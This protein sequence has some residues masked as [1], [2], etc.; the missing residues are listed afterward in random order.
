MERVATYTVNAQ[1]TSTQLND[2]QDVTV[3]LISGANNNALSAAGC[4]GCEWQS[5]TANI[6]SATQIK[7]DAT[8]DWRDRVLT[9]LYYAPTGANEQPGGIADYQYD[10]NIPSLRKG[11]TGRGGLDA[12]SADPSNGNPPVPAA[13][14]SW[15]LEVDANIYLYASTVDGSLWLYNDSGGV[16]K[17]PIL[18]IT[19]TAPT[20]LRP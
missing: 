12:G 7:V 6:L 19:A 14:T 17:I 8:R 15:A 2:L 18:S 5:S 16:L 9:V 1:I 20:G 10:Y 11:Y 3:G 4:D 13:G